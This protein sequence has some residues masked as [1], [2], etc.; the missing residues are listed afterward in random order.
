MARKGLTDT[1][2]K[3]IEPLLPG[4]P[5]DPGRTGIDNRSTVEG[6][7]YI[8]RTGS[9]WRDLPP[10]FGKWNTIHKRF[11]RWVR[12]GVF[13]RIFKSSHGILDLRTVQVDGSFVKVHQHGTG[14]KKVGARPLSQPNGRPLDAAGAGL[15]PS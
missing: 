6:I 3:L 4:K 2:W 7:L 12:G 10:C 15:R 11:R 14:A 13:E 1:Q 9:P 5:S 8:M